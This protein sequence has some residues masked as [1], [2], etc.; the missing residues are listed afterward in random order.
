MNMDLNH[1]S[2]C[3]LNQ[4]DETRMKSKYY[5]YSRELQEI[6]DP[7]K[8]KIWRRAKPASIFLFLLN[9]HS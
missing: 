9:S 2:D 4:E 6:N 3:I 7:Y 5:I 1:L 8:T